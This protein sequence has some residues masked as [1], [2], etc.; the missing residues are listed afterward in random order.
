M[1]KRIVIEK[2]Q[3]EAYQAMFAFERYLSRTQIDPLLKELIKIRASQINGC[4][5][6][7]NIHTKEARKKGESE[8]RIY[9]LSAW[10]ET[11]FFTDTERAVLALTEE[12]THISVKGVTDETYNNALDLLG[13][14]RLA[15]VIMAI[16][17]INAWTRIGVSTHMTPALD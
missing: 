8:Q 6:C 2:L 17:T 10:R 5:Y 9:A 12:I 7:I 13:E 15:Q 16:I 11:P 14:E 1:S 4:A 3:P